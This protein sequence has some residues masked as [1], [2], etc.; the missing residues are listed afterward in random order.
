MK[1]STAGM[2]ERAAGHVPAA[3]RMIKMYELSR[4]DDLLQ[5][6]RY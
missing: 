5:S 4:T 1:N 3:G 2:I 6:T